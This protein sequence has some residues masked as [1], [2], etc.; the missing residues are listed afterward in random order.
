MLDAE[1]G[2]SCSAA[3]AARAARPGRDRAGGASGW[4]SRTSRRTRRCAR[5]SSTAPTARLE[6]EHRRRGASAGPGV[7]DGRGPTAAARRLRPAPRP[8]NGRACSAPV[9]RASRRDGGPSPPKLP[10]TIS[11]DRAGRGAS[12]DACATSPCRRERRRPLPRPRVDRAGHPGE[13]LVVATSLHDVD[14]TLHRLLLIELLVTPAVLA[15]LDVLGLWVVRLGAAAAA[16]RSSRPPARSR[17]ATS[18][19]A[20]SAPTRAPRSAGSGSR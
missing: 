2:S 19:S 3:V 7:A 13:L 15:A 5:S 17:T 12:R 9:S 4:S 14:G 20:S 16:T 8:T 10:A 1:R 6:A 18:R 11:L